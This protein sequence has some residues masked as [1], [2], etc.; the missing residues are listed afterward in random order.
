VVN[1]GGARPAA[2]GRGHRHG[3]A[4]RPTERAV[5]H[6]A[7]GGTSASRR[8]RCCCSD[9]KRAKGVDFQRGEVAH[10]DRKRV[11]LRFE[12]KERPT[13]I[14]DAVNGQSIYAKGSLTID[15]ATGRVE[16]TDFVLNSSHTTSQLIT[17]YE[18]EEKL[19]LWV[20]V[21]FRERYDDERERDRAEII[22]CEARYTNFRRF[23][24]TG[25]IK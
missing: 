1:R 25:R 19:G 17:D 11:T 14:R 8:S 20:P 13:L 22:Q 10:G 4:H 15:A 5:Q 9:P 16:R 6:R 21:L 24:V 18:L 7:L 23:E 2:K 3:R 12:E